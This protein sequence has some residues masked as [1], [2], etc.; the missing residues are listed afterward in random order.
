MHEKQQRLREREA[1]VNERERK[2]LYVE[3]RK[4]EA[5]DLTAAV[6][7]QVIELESVLRDGLSNAPVDPFDELKR[8]FEAPPFDAGGLDKPLLPPEWEAPTPPGL[9]GRLT[10]GRAQHRQD[11]D[12][13]RQEYEQARARHAADESEL[14]ELCLKHLER[15]VLISLPKAPPPNR[16]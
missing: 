6:T 16:K 3:D 7:D 13:K 15:D 1:A 5:A 9:W 10:G 4:A 8:A 12:A 11:L 14:K 2:R